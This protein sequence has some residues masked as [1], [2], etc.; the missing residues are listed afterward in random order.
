M[1]VGHK[2]HG[3]KGGGDLSLVLYSYTTTLHAIHTV[4]CTGPMWDSL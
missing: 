2:R 4:G 1:Y 3:G